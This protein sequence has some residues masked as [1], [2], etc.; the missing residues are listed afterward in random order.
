MIDANPDK[1]P[2]Y[3]MLAHVLADQG[4]NDAALEQVAQA[5]KDPDPS[6]QADILALRGWIYLNME[7]RDE[8]RADFDAVL[9]DDNAPYHRAALLGRGALALAEERFTDARE[10]IEQGIGQD[11]R[12][13]LGHLLLAQLEQAQGRPGRALAELQTARNLILYPGE[14]AALEAFAKDLHP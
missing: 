12:Y 2:G 8:A 1:A 6:V 13:G 3:L 7:R 4:E 11:S 14:R 5:L 9:K 10:P